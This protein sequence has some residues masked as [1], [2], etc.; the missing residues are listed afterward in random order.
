MK[1]FGIASTAVAA[2]SF[3][4]NSVIAADLPSIVIK[5]SKFFYENNG[6]Q[7]YMKG[8]AYQQD[9]AGNG[10][11]SS[12][13]NSY[14]DPLSNGDTCKRD[15]PYMQQLGTNTI[16]VYAIDPTADHDDCMSQLSAA[17]IYVIADLSAPVDGSSI[18]RDT[19]A[20]N[21]A[22]YARYT[23]VVDTMH[24]YT[25][26][27]GFFAGN[28]VSNAPNNTDASA[29]VKAAVRDTKAYI[30]AQNYRTI[31]VGYATN[32]DADI[33][34]NMA[35]YFNCGDSASAIDFWGYNIYS[36]CGDSSYTKSGYD[37]RTE[38]FSTYSVPVFF[39]EYG[40]NEVQPRV[41]TEVQAL[42]GDKMNG[43][44]SG[45][46]VYMYFQET[47]DYGLVSVDGNSVSTLTDFNNLKTQLAS[48][49]PTGVNS[50][51]YSPTNS[52]ASCPTEGTDWDAKASPL[53]PSPNKQLC[54]CM[55]NSLSCVVAS[56]TNTDD[57]SD[58]FGTVCG[59]GDTICAGINANGSTGSYGAYSMCNSTEQL[60]F[61]F[62]Q[63][64]LSQNKASDACDFK[65]AAATK[66]ATSASGTCATLMSQAGTAGTGS[67]TASPTAK[68][69]SSGSSGSSSS[70]GAA[71]PMAAVPSVEHTILPVAFLVTLAALSGMGM[72]L[73]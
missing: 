32:D 31:G 25:N 18:N 73:L 3:L 35:N 62:N 58:L 51:S 11:T 6:T 47:N 56:K 55:F 71:G 65:G 72:V 54:N 22:L 40:C 27:L 61:A 20:W 19:P 10:T 46:I 43:V 37:V 59:Y 24:N 38:E 44:W 28:E 42:Y 7:F 29:F 70:S 5:G 57:F 52:A 30:K 1:G 15:I 53:P 69:G 14:V 48:A 67:V 4:A 8:V 2:T 34:E 63:Y 21:D 9:Y 23:S 49:T 45:G 33:R 12:S 50:A 17:G 26:V 60:A 41:F 16:R 64:Y 36:W 68:G 39:A 66:A 13:G